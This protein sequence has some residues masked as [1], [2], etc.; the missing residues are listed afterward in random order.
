MSVRSQLTT[1]QA[2]PPSSD[3]QSDP[4]FAVWISA[5]TRFEFEG[6]TA[7]SIFPA[8]E[9]GNPF[10]RRFHVEPV[11]FDTYTPLPGP[12]LNIAHVCITTSHVPANST[13]G[14]VGST[15]TPESPLFSRIT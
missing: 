1:F 12:P 15:L 9:F 2:V 3:R 11:S 14:S 6:A 7:T 4:W 8:G 5:Y 10:A 13:L